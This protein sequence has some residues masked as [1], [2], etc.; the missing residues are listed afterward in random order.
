MNGEKASAGRL[1]RCPAMSGSDHGTRNAVL[2]AADAQNSSVPPAGHAQWR[3]SQQGCSQ[4]CTAN[5]LQDSGALPS[6]QR[7]SSER[8]SALH[9]RCPKPAGRLLVIEVGAWTSS[10][11]HSR[12]L[13]RRQG[14]GWGGARATAPLRPPPPSHQPPEGIP[15]AGRPAAGAA[16]VPAPCGHR[17]S[18]AAAAPAP[19][20]STP[21]P[22]SALLQ[23]GT[24]SGSPWRRR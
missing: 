7:C 18:T 3:P 15:S 2:S 6:S 21:P 10:R 20:S 4:A 17:R 1:Q 24:G 13:G 19:R 14:A 16:P 22:L 5:V 12:P 8:S 9:H 23:G 11:K